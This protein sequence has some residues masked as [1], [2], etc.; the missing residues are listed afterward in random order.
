MSK[1]TLEG[2]PQCIS[3]SRTCLQPAK[4]RIL[5]SVLMWSNF[6]SCTFFSTLL[7]VWRPTKMNRLPKTAANACMM[8]WP[9]AKHGGQ[10]CKGTQIHLYKVICGA[11]QTEHAWR[12]EQQNHRAP[13]SR[14]YRFMGSV[15]YSL[16]LI[17]QIIKGIHPQNDKHKALALDKVL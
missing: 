1:H 4:H 3:Q 7:C 17:I 14:I 8:A 11:T 6:K 5:P 13:R 16:T 10:G 15:P 2:T 12:S 9:G